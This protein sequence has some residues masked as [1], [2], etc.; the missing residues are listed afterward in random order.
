MEMVKDKA[1]PL[2]SRFERFDLFVQMFLPRDITTDDLFRRNP[3]GIGEARPGKINIE[4]LAVGA[5]I[6]AIHW[7]LQEPGSTQLLIGRSD[8]AILQ[9]QRLSFG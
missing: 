9:F 2:Y 1:K 5:A 4:I 7:I 3:P 6:L 8:P